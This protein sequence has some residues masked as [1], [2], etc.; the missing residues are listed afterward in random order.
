MQTYNVHNMSSIII[1][2]RTLIFGF[3]PILPSTELSPAA[4]ADVAGLFELSTIQQCYVT[5][6]QSVVFVTVML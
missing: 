4:A 3:L 2:T 6:I 1:I 5:S